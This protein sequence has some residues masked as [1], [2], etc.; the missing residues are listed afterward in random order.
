MIQSIK[1]RDHRA[2][3]V[4]LHGVGRELRSVVYVIALHARHVAAPGDEAR[5]V[6]RV[7]VLHGR[8]STLDRS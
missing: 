8:V 5:V 4:V 7:V 2:C 1:G 6:G 3:R